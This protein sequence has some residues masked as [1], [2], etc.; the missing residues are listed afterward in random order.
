MG[1]FGFGKKHHEAEEES[2]AVDV[3]DAVDADEAT[4]ADETTENADDTAAAG[5]FGDGERGVD[6]GPWDV[7]D[8]NIP[9]YDDY[10][11]IGSLYLPFLQGIELRLKGARQTGTVMGATITLGNSSLEMEAFAAPKSYGLWDDV[12][13]DLLAANEGSR[14]VEGVFGTELILPVKVKDKTLD[15]RIVG[16]DGP[17]WMLRGIFTGPAAQP[18]GDDEEKTTLDKYFSDLVVDRGEEPLAPRDMI[19][20]HAP[21]GPAERA[22]QA[23]AESKDDG[24]DAGKDIPGKPKGPLSKTLETQTQTTLRRGPLFSEV[25]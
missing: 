15:T 25:R 5:G 12:R 7:D 2:K 19:P 18:D 23:E 3:D 13:A 20:M 1:L 16:I 17:R 9:D 24:Q 4:E 14:E 22:K 21:V 8:E 10:L 11:D 6:H